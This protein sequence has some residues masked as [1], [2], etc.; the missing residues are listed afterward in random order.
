MCAGKRR[1]RLQDTSQQIPERPNW[2]F[3]AV[4]FPNIRLF[5]YVFLTSI[6]DHALEEREHF[7]KDPQSYLKYRNQVE[8]Y[9][10]KVQLIHLV[11]SD[12][13]KAFSNATEESMARRLTRKPEIFEHIRL[14][15]PVACHRVSPGP[16]YL[17]YLVED[18]LNFIPKGIKTVTKTGIVD[19]D[20]TLREVDAIICATGFDTYVQPLHSKLNGRDLSSDCSSFKL[21]DTPIYGQN[22]VPL[23]PHGRQNPVPTCPFV[24]HR[25]P[26]CFFLL[27][28]MRHLVLARRSI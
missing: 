1:Y 10:N 16:M 9:V 26:I 17:E 22:G 6:V 11:G 21:T 27:G 20:G 3:T 5:S 12:M 19:D 8:N 28:L 15:Y 23:I 7:A 14:N 13:N 2:T 18:K 24:L 25:C 4:S